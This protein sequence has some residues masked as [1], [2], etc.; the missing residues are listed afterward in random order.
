M[1]QAGQNART[2]ENTTTQQENAETNMRI[3][4]PDEN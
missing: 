3:R 1:Q 4:F 2:R